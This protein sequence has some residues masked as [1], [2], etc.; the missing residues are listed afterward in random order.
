MSQADTAGS[1][2]TPDM[3]ANIQVLLLASD[4]ELFLFTVFRL[5]NPVDEEFQCGVKVDGTRWTQRIRKQ[6][7]R[8]T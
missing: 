7:S 6:R 4:Q 5:T 1:F 2:T 3:S 8:S